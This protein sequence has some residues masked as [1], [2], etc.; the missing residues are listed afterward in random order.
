MV[1]DPGPKLTPVLKDADINF[2]DPD[3]LIIKVLDKGYVK[4]KINRPIAMYNNG[5]LK[6]MIDNLLKK[7]PEG[8]YIVNENI[9]EKIRKT[10]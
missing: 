4:K 6:M 9:P 5:L 7:I 8:C 2:A 3:H 1:Q 10:N